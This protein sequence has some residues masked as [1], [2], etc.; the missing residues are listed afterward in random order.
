ML[1]ILY[2]TDAY[3]RT[4]QGVLRHALAIGVGYFSSLLSLS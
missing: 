1:C 3:L 4:A 2:Q